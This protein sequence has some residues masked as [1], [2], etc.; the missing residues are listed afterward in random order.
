MAP[1]GPGAA[2]PLTAMNCDPAAGDRAAEKALGL[3]DQALAALDGGDPPAALPLAARGL[4]TLEAAGLGGGPDAAALLVA[5]AEIEECLGR[6]GDAAVTI[7]A[8][9]TILGDAI[10]GGGDGDILLLW[11]QAQ[12]RL[13]GLERLAGDF[14]TAAARLRAVLDRAASAFGEASMAVVSAANAL[15]VVGKYASDFDA[16]E[17]AYRRAAAALDGLDDPDPLVEAGL[18]HNLGG[19]AHSRGDAAG[20]ISLAERGAALRAEGLGAGHPD[21]ARDLNALGALYHLARRYEDAAGAYRRALAVFEDSYGPDHFEVAMTCANLAVLAGDRG[22]FADAESLGRR[23]LRILEA[24]LG[25]GDAEVGLTVLNLAA[26]VAGQGRRAEAAALA[27]RAAAI[28]TARLP[29]GHPHVTAAR[30]ALDRLAGE[31]S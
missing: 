19:L 22:R 20:G 8:A 16:A 27:A 29:A 4:A 18:L 2:T 6:F 3:R 5:V 25:P 23:P 31:A 14:D 21:V 17:A 24:V 12:E 7:A 11:C 10:A 13:A 15:G 1:V 28:L 9:I 26:A 30:E